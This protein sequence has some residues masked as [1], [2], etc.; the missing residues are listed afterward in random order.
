MVLNGW[1]QVLFE[2]ALPTPVADA[3]RV[4]RRTGLPP[5]AAR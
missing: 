5:G 3:V 4:G 2:Q 1:R